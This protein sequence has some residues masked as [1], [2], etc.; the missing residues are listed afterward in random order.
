LTTSVIV[1]GSTIGIL[2]GG[3][4]GRMTAMAARSLGY[5]VQV[6]DPDPSCPAR[7]VVDACFVGSWDDARAAADLARGCDVI[8]LEIE[9]I[10]IASLE[11]AARH[12]PV[13]PGKEILAMVQDRIRQKNWLREQGYPVGAYR[14]IYAEDDLLQAVAELGPRI[15][16]KGARGGYDGRGQVKLD[17]L[18]QF[19]GYRDPGDSLAQ[20]VRAAWRALG[21]R[22]CVAE[23]AFDL[24]SEISVMVARNPRGEV[25]AYP[26]A[27][28]LHEHQILVWSALPS[29]IPVGLENRAQE[30]ATTMAC[31]LKLEGLLAV[32]MFVTSGGGLYV[33]ELAPRPHNSY[34][35]SQR[36]CVTSQFEQAVRAVCDLPLG[37]VRIMR[38]AAIANLLGDLWL[39]NG[40]QGEPHF[41][42]ALAVPEV[43]LHLYEKHTAR[44]GRK[45]GHLSATADTAEEAVARVMEAK[46]RL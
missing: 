24:E 13:R 8:T 35:A 44:A 32:E 23:Q 1:Q 12:A 26:A 4:L 16:L 5:R 20:R 31:Q 40:L 30:I 34:H 43:S 18:D 25:V 37:D 14:A 33:N 9:Q 27:T 45:M 3:Q 28:N 7:F 42:Q 19:D 11:A 29:S 2:G 21:E 39:K 22:P 17:E 41:A 10:S 46:S 36:C 38:P 6:M 15:Y